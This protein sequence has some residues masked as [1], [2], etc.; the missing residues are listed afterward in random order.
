MQTTPQEVHYHRTVPR[1]KVKGGGEKGD[2]AKGERAKAERAKAE[3]A[4]GEGEEK[5]E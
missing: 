3:R 4:K 1:K 5:R 2:R